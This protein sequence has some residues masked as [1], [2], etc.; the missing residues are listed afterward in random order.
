[1]ITLEIADVW[2]R[3]I[4]AKEA[5]RGIRMTEEEVS[6]LVSQSLKL[7]RDQNDKLIPFKPT[8]VQIAVDPHNNH[9]YGLGDNG[10]V[11]YS[12]LSKDKEP[13]H[14]IRWGGNLP[15]K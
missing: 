3:L 6:V 13:K 8:L 14:W 9:L 7:I 2:N 12:A 11:Y 15:D 5:G 10:T 1:M 4:D